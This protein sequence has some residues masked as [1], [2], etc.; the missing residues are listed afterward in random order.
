MSIEVP[1]TG[2]PID[3]VGAFS[4]LKAAWGEGLTRELARGLLSLVWIETGAGKSMK[5]FNAGNISASSKYTG[6]VWRPTW[7]AEPTADTSPRDRD[8]HEKMLKGQAPSAFRAYDSLAQGFQDFVAQLQHT[9]PEVLV[10]AETGTPDTFRQALAQKYSHDYSNPKATATFTSLW[11]DFDPIVL[12]LPS[13]APEV[14]ATADP[15]AD[16]LPGL[17]TGSSQLPLPYSGEPS[18]SIPTEEECEA[19]LLYTSDAADE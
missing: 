6:K 12:S 17:P 1:M 14:T 9:F 2:T 5:N 7:F 8:L 13:S 11:R 3:K 16:P 10:N 18:V 15:L 4:A 19:C